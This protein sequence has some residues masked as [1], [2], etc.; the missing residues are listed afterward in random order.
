[1]YFR[2]TAMRRLFG[3]TF[4][5]DD[6]LITMDIVKGLVKKNRGGGGWAGAFQN[7]VVRKHTTHPFHLA[8]N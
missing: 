1:M 6:N 5:K 3:P 7:V 8:Q 2:L 4:A